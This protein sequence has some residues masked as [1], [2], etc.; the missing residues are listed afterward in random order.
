[1]TAGF[2]AGFF[3]IEFGLLGGWERVLHSDV[4]VRQS[5]WLEPFYNLSYFV[6]LL[7]PLTTY[8]VIARWTGENL[9]VYS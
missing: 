4:A 5:R 9:F 7:I 8:L 6:G 1:M 3:L 2:V